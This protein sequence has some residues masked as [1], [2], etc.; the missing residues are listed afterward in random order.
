[1]TWEYGLIGL[2]VG[3]AIGAIAMRF[4]SKTLRSQHQIQYELEKTRAELADH[5]TD[6]KD[7]FTRSTELLDKMAQDYRELHQHL[8]RSSNEM[9]P[10]HPGHDPRSVWQL[11]EVEAGNDQ[12]PIEIPRDYSEGA[13]GILR[14]TTSK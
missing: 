8:T 6:L 9:L 4:G 13:S 14:G 12:T 7:H 5:K 2:V 11:S 10:Q 3:I 1:M